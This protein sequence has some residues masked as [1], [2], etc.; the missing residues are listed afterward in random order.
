MGYLHD[1]GDG[2]AG[3]TDCGQ[4]PHTIEAGHDEIEHDGI[5]R[6]GLAT[7]ENGHDS[8]AGIDGHRLIAAIAYHDLDQAPLYGVVIGDQ[9]VG[10]H[11]FPH[12]LRLFVPN[13]GTLADAA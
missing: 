5:D 11:G 12:A 9:N 10:G 2:E 4:N 13:R 3:L 8:V 7:G 1:H 6:G